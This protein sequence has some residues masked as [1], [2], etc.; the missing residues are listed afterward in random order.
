MSTTHIPF[1]F[2]GRYFASLEEA[3]ALLAASGT[4]FD[5]DCVYNQTPDVLGLQYLEDGSY[6]LGYALRPGESDANAKALWAQRV[7]AQLT[8]AQSHFELFTY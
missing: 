1:G 8:D 7:D 4:D 5:S 2:Y 3:E 6:I